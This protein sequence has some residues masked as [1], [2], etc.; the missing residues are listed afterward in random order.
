M[1]TLAFES[2]MLSGSG[3]TVT[4]H[5]AVLPLKVFTVTTV[6]PGFRPFT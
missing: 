6:S 3:F 1:V 5:C 2:M 4:V